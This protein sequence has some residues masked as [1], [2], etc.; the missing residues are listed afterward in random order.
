MTQAGYRTDWRD[1]VDPALL[2]AAE[3]HAHLWYYMEDLDIDTIGVP[4]FYPE[5][6]R[7]TPNAAKKNLIYTVPGGIFVH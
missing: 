1:V 3:T 7:K 6:G 4:V 2:E 5:V